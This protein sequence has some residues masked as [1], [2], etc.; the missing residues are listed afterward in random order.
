M[1]LILI[2]VIFGSIWVFC[3]FILNISA[4][5]FTS[6]QSL[7]VLFVI[8]V[9]FFPPC[10]DRPFTHYGQAGACAPPAER[11]RSKQSWIWPPV[12]ALRRSLPDFHSLVHFFRGEW[13][14]AAEGAT[15]AV[16]AAGALPPLPSVHGQKEGPLSHAW[17]RQSGGHV[18]RLWHRRVE[19]S[20]VGPAHSY[21]GSKGGSDKESGCD[22]TDFWFMTTCYFLTCVFSRREA[23]S[24]FKG[25]ERCV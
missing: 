9:C 22:C 11:T 21:R 3:K 19:L 12:A 16:H 18:W 2:V 24:M 1:H 20:G 6:S 25:S 8:C 23:F 10:T 15:D 13:R 17:E 7:R 14:A 4:L 5:W